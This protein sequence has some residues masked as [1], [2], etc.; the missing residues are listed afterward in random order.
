MITGGLLFGV[1]IG[2]TVAL[3]RTQ[4][5]ALVESQ[6]CPRGDLNISSPGPLEGKGKGSGSIS[7]YDTQSLA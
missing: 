1:E 4:T 3:T 2:D 5:L 7:P 6:I